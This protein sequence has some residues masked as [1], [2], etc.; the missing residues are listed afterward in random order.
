MHQISFLNLAKAFILLKTEVLN[1][2][3]CLSFDTDELLAFT[4]SRRDS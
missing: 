4:K 2:K 1:S 3:N